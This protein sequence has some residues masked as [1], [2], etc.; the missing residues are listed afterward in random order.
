M[1]NL[2]DPV[3]LNINSQLIHDLIQ[4]KVVNGDEEW[5]KEW[6]N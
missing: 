4:D 6:K 1:M 5:M 2:V 3:C